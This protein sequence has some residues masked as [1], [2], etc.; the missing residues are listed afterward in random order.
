MPDSAAQKGQAIGLCVALKMGIEQMTGAPATIKMIGG[1]RAQDPQVGEAA[2]ASGQCDFIFIGKGVLVQPDL[3]NLVKEERESEIRPCIGCGVC[4]DVQLQEGCAARCSGNAVLG[5]GD[6]SYEIPAAQ[7]KKKVLVVGGGVAGV[8]AA[9][10]AAKRGHSVS[11]YE[12]SG[13][14]G[15][16]IFYAAAPP[17]K[18]NMS[19]LIPYLE[20]QLKQYQVDV[21]LNTELTAQQVLAL[22]PD[23]V[24]CATGVK[25]SALPIPGFD[26]TKSAKGV[27]MGEDTGEHVV[28]VGG[29]SVGCET[30]EFLAEKGKK[31]VVIE[32]LDTMA[33]KMVNVARTILMG[34]LKGLGVVLLTSC[35]CREITESSVTYE[36]Q[37]GA[38]HTVSADTVVA[39]IGDKPEQGLYQELVGNV[40]ALYNVG[41]SNRPDSIAEAVTE[42]YYCGLQ[43]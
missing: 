41:D 25:P 3:V 12:K 43:L 20:Q 31:V 36:D 26:L 18:E 7:D 21:H 2:L 35:R 8:E 37:Q 16:Q 34:H 22:T 38:V 39:A 24:I 23:A 13:R 15:G 9:R 1:G 33:E 40:P 4:I 27:L 5:H 28:I 19:P 29:G 42:G 32:L 17:H 6:N 11:L 30:A 14:I 10:I